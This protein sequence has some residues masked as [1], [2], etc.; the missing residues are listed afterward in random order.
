MGSNSEAESAP[1]D[2]A[3]VMARWINGTEIRVSDVQRSVAF[4]Q[5]IFGMPV[6][7]YD[8]DG[9]RLRIGAGPHY[10]LIAPAGDGK[11]GIVN[12]S[13]AI[14]PADPTE[15]VRKLG[16][17]GVS[18]ARVEPRGPTG[19]PTVSFVDSQGYTV[20]LEMVEPSPSPA[21]RNDAPIPTVRYSHITF[22]GDRDFYQRIFG[23][24]VQAKQGPAFMLRVGPGPDFL[25]GL[26]G[27][28]RN[29]EPAPMPG[30]FCLAM[31][32]YDPNRVTGLFM[33]AGLKPVEFTDLLMRTPADRMTVRNRLRQV[34]WNGGGRTHPLGSYET[35]AVDHDGIEFQIQDVSYAGGSGA[36]G[37]IVP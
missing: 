14:D 37:Q 31:E 17:L 3:P 15:V 35:Y 10:L 20:L 18:E 24:P 26:D 33:D 23:M 4:Y 9:V 16:A 34:D 11:A 22:R 8:G 1:G 36:N 13:L 2:T 19:A 27:L 32:G 7:P 12:F 5:Q 21:E 30:H 6:L 25:I 28:P 29:T